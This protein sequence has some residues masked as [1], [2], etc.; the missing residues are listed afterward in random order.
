MA[1]PLVIGVLSISSV[2]GSEQEW[3]GFPLPDSNQPVVIERFHYDMRGSVRLLFFWI[4][5]SGVGGGWVSRIRSSGDQTGSW[6]DGWEVLFGSK[7][8]AV[9]GGHNRWGYARELAFWDEAEAASSKPALAKTVFEGFMTKS[10]EDSLSEVRKGEGAASEET[11][12]EGTVSSVFPDHASVEIRRFVAPAV[13]SFEDPAGI[14]GQYLDLLKVNPPDEVRTLTHQPPPSQPL[15]F[16]T[17][18]A[19]CLSDVIR[20]GVDKKRWDQ[21]KDQERSY[22]YNARDY[23]LEIKRVKHHDEVELEHN[24]SVRDVFEIDFETGRKGESGGHDFSVWTS[25]TGKFAGIP[26]KIVDKPRWWLKVELTLDDS[27]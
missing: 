26:I 19:A 8:E 17:A 11:A 16:L 5:K 3:E 18:V 14:A 23:S 7:P 15:G 25:A 12:F 27:R 9:P 2:F 1:W 21:L 6:F 20:A 4:G 24:Q 22:V 10:S 13:A